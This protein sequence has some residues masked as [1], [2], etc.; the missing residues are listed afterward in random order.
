MTSGLILVIEDKR[1]MLRL[2]ERVLGEHHEVLTAETGE[3]G[4]A[5]FEREAV[6]LVLSDIKL[7]DL[8][9]LA[10]LEAMKQ[11]KPEVEVLLMTAYG[12]VASAVEAMK[13]GALDY[14]TKPFEP[15]EIVLV[16]QRAMERMALQSK[17]HH[18]Q[19]E[20]E[21]LY[22]F[23]NIVGTSPA[24]QE[25]YALMRKVVNSD[26]TVLITGDSGTGKELVARAI[27]YTSN[28]RTRHFVP[29]NCGAIP[30]DLLESEMFGHEKGAFSGA[31]R[32]KR[33]LIEEAGGGTL[34]LDEISELPLDLQV[35]INR[36]LQDKQVR[37]VGERAD[38]PVDVRFLTATNRDLQE[39]VSQG[40]FR[41][42]LFY[43]I[44]VYPIPIPP[45][46]DRAEDIPLLINH[47]VAKYK[48]T[49]DEGTS[50]IDSEAVKALQTCSWPGNVRELENAI[51]RATLLAEEDPIKLEH[52]PP[53]ISERSHRP[54]GEALVNLPYHEAV[55]A[56]AHDFS[57]AYLVA[58]LK[59]HQGNVTRAAKDTGIERESFHRLLKKHDVKAKE[60]RNS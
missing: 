43:R 48:K 13:K 31:H 20:V 42:D 46:R 38:R 9:G 10:L 39:L 51:E 36:V 55:Q 28:R 23:A 3:E 29:V 49:K 15:D 57:K 5:I 14:I 25:V 53:S 18:L 21:S 24:M 60:F 50:G 41:E 19:R 30:K 40:L 59:R 34:F 35:K 47:F 33:G 17:A 27:H 8:D 7:P 26:T 37:R 45:L 54:S 1:N 32:T 58:V 22:G 56:A 12:S 52:L 16:V 44:N 11:R 4:L 6:D 2:L